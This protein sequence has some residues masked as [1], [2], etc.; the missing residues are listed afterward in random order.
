MSIHED[1]II[2]VTVPS[3][4]WMSVPKTAKPASHRGPESTPRPMGLSRADTPKRQTPTPTVTPSPLVS[5]KSPPMSDARST[6]E[7]AMQA[8]PFLAER[9]GTLGRGSLVAG[10]RQEQILVAIARAHR[11]SRYTPPRAASRMC[12]LLSSLLFNQRQPHLQ[13]FMW[14]RSNTSPHV[15]QFLTVLSG[16]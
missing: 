15:P 4:Q 14:D 7:T 11:H 6:E 1:I 3:S 9:R 13:N 10:G 2:T 5:P 16:H 12:G 8:N